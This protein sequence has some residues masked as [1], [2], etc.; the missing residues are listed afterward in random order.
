MPVYS[1]M[2]FSI[3][4][5]FGPSRPA[6]LRDAPGDTFDF[7]TIRVASYPKIESQK[8]RPKISASICS[9][10]VYISLFLENIFSTIL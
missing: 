10:I 2:A 8:I 9:Q 3:L 1:N 5:V 4:E 6:S 7:V